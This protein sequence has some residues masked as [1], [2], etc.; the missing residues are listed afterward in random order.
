MAEAPSRR[1]RMGIQKIRKNVY[2]NVEYLGSNVVCVDTEKGLVLVD[3]PMLPAD[4]RHWKGFALALN[5]AGVK[6]LV[7]THAHF[8]HVVGNRQLGGIGIMHAEE[9]NQLF[10]LNEEGRLR[11][12]IAALFPT[13]TGEETDFIASEPRVLP[14]ISFRDEI[15]LFLG[16]CTVRAFAIGGHTK[17]SIGV[18]LEEHRI[19]MTGD[20]VTAGMHPVKSSANF[21][22]WM[23]G[24]DRM[25]SLEIETLVPG[26]GDVCGR[27]ELDKSLEYFRQL[28]SLAE[29]LA[30]QGSS[31]EEVIRRVHE[32]MFHFYPL[33][34][35]KEGPAR[36]EGIKNVFD[37]GTGRLYDEILAGSE[38]R[39][40]ET[41][42]SGKK[43]SVRG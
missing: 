27:E 8:E 42:H 11:R 13:V 25:G 33:D 20:C 29:G 22:E 15:K 10:A 16:D 24:L 1:E 19:L 38:N 43:S 21:R 37:A 41:L 17:G 28:W 7:N 3:T 2:V 26:H 35:A 14:E 5:P 12:M 39:A 4:I 36:M 23:N 9:A 30:K 34:P 32:K 18:Y 40:P 31:R 6:Y